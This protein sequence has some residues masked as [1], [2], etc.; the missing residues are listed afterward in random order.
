MKFKERDDLPEIETL[1]ITE[2][3]AEK[4]QGAA[5]G[6]A[7]RHLTAQFFRPEEPDEISARPLLSQKLPHSLGLRHRLCN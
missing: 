4:L 2:K 6:E 1:T 3:I 5:N 7:A